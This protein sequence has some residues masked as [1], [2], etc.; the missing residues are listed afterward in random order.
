[1]ADLIEE[2]V[3]DGDGVAVAG[4]LGYVFADGVLASLTNAL[5]APIANPLVTDANGYA[6]GYVTFSSTYSVKWNWGGRERYVSVHH[7]DIGIAAAAA[8]AA[9]DAGIA[10]ASANAAAASAATAAAYTSAKSA[11]TAALITALRSWGF[12]ANQTHNT[13]SADIATISVGTA[14][15]NSV[16]NGAA[17]FSPAIARSSNKLTWVGGPL[18]A[19]GYGSGSHTY[20]ARGGYNGSAWPGGAYNGYEFTHTGT[21]FDIQVSQNAG[22]TDNFRVIVNGK[23]AGTA[24][25]GAAGTLAYVNVS[26]PSSATRNIR[27]ETTAPIGAINVTSASEVVSIARSYPMIPVIGDS[28]VEGT[29]ADN[30]NLAGEAQT[31]IKLIGGRAA[32]AGVGQTGILNDAAGAKVNW[33]NATRLTDLTLSG[34]TDP[35]TS[36]AYTP[37]MGVVMASLNDLNLGSTYWGG[38]ANYLEAVRKGTLAII[39]AWIAANPGKPLV[40][41]G[42]TWTNG[43]PIPDTFRYRDGIEQ[44]CSAAG[45]V[46]SNVWFID[47][48]NPHTALRSGTMA[49]SDTT[50]NTTNGSKVITN[51]PSTSG[52][53]VGGAVSGSGIPTGSRIMSIDSGTQVTID[54]DQSATATGVALKF[55]NDQ[56][57]LYT[58]LSSGDTTHPSQAGHDYDAHWMAR[59]LRRLI[60]TEF[61]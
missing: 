29:G 25:I 61:N 50:G 51:I 39:A 17:W 2:T 58:S 28:F 15:A 26:F 14:F 10:V 34:V 60:L 36:A 6:S 31:L 18:T 23:L 22:G 44:A 38:A 19:Q 42:P 9:E 45:G 52:Y 46:A 40:V 32:T 11:N 24:T 37:A 3:F 41:F 48:L 35:I 5:G 55:R 21:T 56:S 8:S 12:F 33:Q 47:R 7:A 20:G 54:N 53:A 4:A 43:T 13:P 16:I 1:M 30:F 27:I 57:A 59:E 49:Y